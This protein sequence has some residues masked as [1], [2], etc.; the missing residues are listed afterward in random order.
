MLALGGINFLMLRKYSPGETIPRLRRLVEAEVGIGI[1]IVLTAASLTAQPPAVD[2]P[3]DTVQLSHIVQRFKPEVPLA[4][5]SESGRS[6]DQDSG[7]G[8]LAKPIRRARPWA[9]P[10]K[11]WRSR[12]ARSPT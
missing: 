12:S 6:L 5:Q 9:T 10:A 3:N 11:A 4:S 1:T 2:L 8:D 7:T